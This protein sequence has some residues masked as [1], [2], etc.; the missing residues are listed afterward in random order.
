MWAAQVPDCRRD[1][2]SSASSLQGLPAPV[3]AAR[4]PST[5]ETGPRQMPKS[6]SGK[7]PGSSTGAMAQWACLQER[8]PEVWPVRGGRLG[9]HPRDQWDGHRER[10]WAARR[11][12]GPRRRVV[13]DD[14]DGRQWRVSLFWSGQRR[15]HRQGGSGRLRVHAIAANVTLSGGDAQQDFMADVAPTQMISG[16]VTDAATG[17]GLAGVS[18]A[19]SGAASATTRSAADGSYSFASLADGTYNVAPTLS[20]YFFDPVNAA[21]TL[22]GADAAQSFSAVAALPITGD[23]SGPALAGEGGTATYTLS[24]T[25]VGTASLTGPLSVDITLPSGFWISTESSDGWTCGA[26]PTGYLCTWNADLAAGAA[27]DLHSLTFNVGPPYAADCGLGPSP[28]VIVSATLRGAATRQVATA[29]RTPN[30]ST[31]QANNFPIA[32]DDGAVVVGT[33]PIAIDVLANDTDP[34]GDQLTVTSIVT[35]PS[36][37]D[38]T[39]NGD[40]TLM[41]TPRAPLGGPDIFRYRVTDSMGA[42]VIAVVTVTPTQPV[43]TWSKTLIDIGPVAVGRIAEG[44]AW[45]SGTAGI[46][47]DARIDPMSSS[48]IATALTG[49]G[50]DLSQ[51]VSDPLA[52]RST[53]CPSSVAD[54]SCMAPAYFRPSTTVGR[55]SVARLVLSNLFWGGAPVTT[56]LVVVGTSVD[57]AQALATIPVAAAEDTVRTP[58]DVPVQID[59][60]GNDSSLAGK[61]LYLA[62]AWAC[63]NLAAILFDHAP[64]AH[65]SGTVGYGASQSMVYTPTAGFA[66]TTAFSYGASEEE[67]AGNP[68]GCRFE[69]NV[70]FATVTVTVGGAST[71]TIAKSGSGTVAGTP[72]GIDCGATCSADYSAGTVVTLNATPSA[73]YVFAGWS[74][75]GCTGTGACVATVNGP[76]TVTASFALAQFVLAVTKSGTGDGTIISTPGGIDCGATCSAEYDAGT[77]VTLT[78]TPATGSVFA[79]WSGGCTGLGTCRLTIQN[80]TSVAVTFVL[81]P[82]LRATKAALAQTGSALAAITVHNGDPVVFRLQAINDPAPGQTAVGSTTGSATITDT[83]PEGLSYV[84]VG[85]DPRC[86]VAASAQAAGGQ[87]VTCTDAGLIAPGRELT[88]DIHAQVGAAVAGVGQS[89]AL[90]N[91]ATVSTPNDANPADDTS[92]PVTVTVVG[93]VAVSLSVA[94]TGAGD[95]VVTSIPAGIACG[96]TCRATVDP[97]ATVILEAVPAPGSAFSGWAGG[98]CTGTAPCAVSVTV[99]TAVVAN[100][101]L[102]SGP[103]SGAFTPNMDYPTGV[104][105]SGVALGDLR[106]VGHQDIVVANYGRAVPTPTGGGV[107]VFPGNGDG[108]FGGKTDYPTAGNPTAVALGDLRGSGVLDIVVLN[109]QISV[110]L[111]SGDGTFG[112][113]TDVPTGGGIP[114][115]LALADVN[116]D[117]KTDVLV[118]N[119]TVNT[120]EIFLGIGDGTLASPT[121]LWTGR[122][123]SAFA[124]ADLNGDGNLDIVVTN[125]GDDSASVFLGHGDGTFA[126]R[127]DLRVGSGSQPIALAIGDLNGNGT[128][129]MVVASTGGSLRGFLGNGDGTF[130]LSATIGLRVRSDAIALAD[131]NGDGVL[132]FITPDYN[133]NTVVVWFGTGNGFLSVVNKGEYA[134][135][136]QPQALVLGELS[137]DGKVDLVSANHDGTA[138]VL[139]GAPPVL[140]I[141]N[142]GERGGDRSSGRHRLWDQ[143]QRRL[144]RGHR[145]DAQRHACRR[146]RPREVERRLH[147]PGHWD[148]HPDRVRP[149]HDRSG[150]RTH[151][152][153]PVVDQ[154]SAQSGTADQFLRLYVRHRQCRAASGPECTPP[155]HA[156]SRHQLHRPGPGRDH[157][158]GCLYIHPGVAHP[159]M[160]LAVRRRRCQ[161][162][163]RNHGQ[164]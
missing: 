80:D 71:L 97:G 111:N 119:Q 148:V 38:V 132:D 66:G 61:P 140:T 47:L 96:A 60:L 78:A 34:D 147:V 59:V 32:A 90:F 164:A 13:G 100:F 87:V 68:P 133:R 26:S 48:E 14:G 16:V 139:L 149:T 159:R 157:R 67:C 145:G 120:L 72:G 75:A 105:P 3:L 50:Y 19:L 150:L 79:G 64:C 57:P 20:G 55:V 69:G 31:G 9:V 37:G 93:P 122:D 141:V 82:N 104:A 129:D 123:P 124:P 110:F 1:T 83:L 18:M 135:G 85:S 17:N 144:Q 21:V 76:L 138:S 160:P 94:K 89:V 136:G 62:S 101:S 86:T 117:G 10:R 115:A 45:V 42:S 106:G 43:L 29:I 6:L 118:V 114:A 25:N 153:R 161:C 84:V 58:L 88:F 33:I 7:P 137:G 23:L 107:S 127:A 143:L 5:S 22:A 155:R 112:S 142:S 15:L 92:S 102:R 103:P 27:T 70:Y 125:A 158:R 73:G 63:G 53:N 4:A 65:P 54:Q 99:A 162:D 128:Q 163:G 109:G 24:L 154:D 52:F 116:G 41:Y 121:T 44:R 91:I 12:R 151:Q 35:P 49:T 39:I 11:D 152:G 113:R 98:G 36:G 2:R 8:R 30:S 130:T 134:T 108:T 46:N 146:I 56:S 40:N 51:A 81:P 126:P 156:P 77:V 95:G 28:C 74:G 131:L